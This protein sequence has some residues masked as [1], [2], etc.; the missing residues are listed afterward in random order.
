MS[1]TMQ[2][3]QQAAAFFSV[4]DAPPTLTSTPQDAGLA[5]RIAK[6]TEFAARN[7]AAIIPLG[8]GLRRLPAR[9]RK[10]SDSISRRLP[11]ASPARLLRAGPSFVDMMKERQKENPEYAFLHGG[12]GADYYRWALYCRLYNHPLDQPLQGQAAGAQ[13]QAAGGGAGA[14]GARVSRPGQRYYSDGSRL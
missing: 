2:P 3:E 10:S 7:G 8:H 14:W 12:E 5:Q 9:G 4:W 11:L 6:L 1:T 13:Q